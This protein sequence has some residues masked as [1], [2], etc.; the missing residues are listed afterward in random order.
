MYIYTNLGL[1]LSSKD[2]EVAYRMKSKNAASPRPIM[3][4]FISR[5]VRNE[6]YERRRILKGKEGARVYICENL[7]ASTAEIARDARLVKDKRLHSCWTNGGCVFVKQ[8]E[9]EKPTA[10]YDHTTLIASC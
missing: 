3:V 2:I 4:T 9:A 10:V 8:T 1:N 5:K 7:T 6:V